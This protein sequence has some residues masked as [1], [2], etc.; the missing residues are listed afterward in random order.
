MAEDKKETLDDIDLE[1]ENIDEL[2]DTQAPEQTVEKPME[3][4]KRLSSSDFYL[5]ITWIVNTWLKVVCDFNWLV[6]GRKCF[7]CGRYVEFAPTF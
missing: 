7:I 1:A 4:K 5:P 2:Q 3:I 6:I